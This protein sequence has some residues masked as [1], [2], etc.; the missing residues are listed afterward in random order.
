MEL[1]KS[2]IPLKNIKHS[3]DGATQALKGI[4][5]NASLKA[6]QAIAELIN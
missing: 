3:Y 1:K 2:V 4:S 5:L 6:A